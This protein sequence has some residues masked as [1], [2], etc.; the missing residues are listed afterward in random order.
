MLS[1]LRAC[2]SVAELGD[3]VL[4]YI[5]VPEPRHTDAVADVLT[6]LIQLAHERR[7]AYAR[8]RERQA[9]AFNEGDGSYRP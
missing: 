2:R 9:E 6:C 5:D 1:V 3:H 4:R 8:L 7:V